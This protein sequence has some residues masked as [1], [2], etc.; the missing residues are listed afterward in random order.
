MAATSAVTYLAIAGVATAAVGTAASI[1]NSQKQAGAA[2]DAA[3]AA[4]T[5]ANQQITDAKAQQQQNLNSQAQATATQQA[6]V[7]AISNPDGDTLITN[8]LGATG[9]G[10]TGAPAQTDLNS[11]QPT[12]GMIQPSGKST[13]G[14]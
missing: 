7:R 8:P 2:K 3:N 9:G 5:A 10:S 13:V 11:P 4:N 6:R 1:D 14:G 12:P